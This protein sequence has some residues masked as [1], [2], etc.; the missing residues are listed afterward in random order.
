VADPVDVAARALAR[1][2]RTEADVRRLLT[3]KGVADAD[4]DDALDA[5]RRSGAVDDERFALTGAES[6]AR[7]G[8]GDAAITFRLRREGLDE[9]LADRA[10]AALE[11]EVERAVRLAARR[12]ASAKTA[13]WLAGRGFDSDSVESALRAVAEAQGAELG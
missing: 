13:R 3:A 10:V 6:L 2:D 4:A 1:R 9:E 11:P 12:D 8:F 5:L 7:R